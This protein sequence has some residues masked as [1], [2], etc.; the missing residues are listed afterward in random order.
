[1]LQVCCEHT[2]VCVGLQGK[3]WPGLRFSSEITVLG[4]KNGAE[5]A[6]WGGWGTSGNDLYLLVSSHSKS[7]GFLAALW[8]VNC[9]AC[10]PRCLKTSLHQEYITP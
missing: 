3:L 7:V 4:R 8:F 9:D 5:A 1:M 6:R 2:N 10:L